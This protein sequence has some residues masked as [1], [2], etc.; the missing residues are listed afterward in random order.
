MPKTFSHI[1]RTK[2]WIGERD[3]GIMPSGL[4]HVTVI[5]ESTRIRSTMN[6]ILGRSLSCG[7]NTQKVESCIAARH[8]KKNL[9]NLEM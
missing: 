8:N 6:L 5:L 7:R 3:P 1:Q 4:T 2:Y 9:K